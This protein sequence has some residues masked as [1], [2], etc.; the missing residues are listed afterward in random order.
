[1]PLRILSAVFFSILR[2]FS[3]L[4]RVAGSIHN[5]LASLLMLNPFF[6][7]YSFNFAPRV[8]EFPGVVCAEIVI[9]KLPFETNDVRKEIMAR[10]FRFVLAF[11]F[12]YQ[13]SFGNNAERSFS[14]SLEGRL[15]SCSQDC[16]VVLHTPTC[17]ANCF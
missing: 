13:L 4:R 2:P 15:R 17:S 7:R 3:H 12:H 16:I 5:S 9:S 10:E 1:M 14:N 8:V 11:N 6:R